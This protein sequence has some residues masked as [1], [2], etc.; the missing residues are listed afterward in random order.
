MAKCQSC[1]RLL[2]LHKASLLTPRHCFVTVAPN[3]DEPEPNRC[4]MSS[5]K[6]EVGHTLKSK[7]RQPFCFSNHRERKQDIG[8]HYLS[9]PSDGFA[10]IIYAQLQ[11]FDH[12]AHNFIAKGLSATSKGRAFSG[13][14]ICQ[15]NT[16]ANRCL[17]YGRK[18][19]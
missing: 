6:I 2:Y 19:P 9:K 12:S 8:P 17:T 3:P 4:M 13:P 16:P 11:F 5:Q 14:K 10:Q 18:P 7:M 1:D 15:R